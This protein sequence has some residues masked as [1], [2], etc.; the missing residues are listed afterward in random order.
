MSGRRQ[1]SPVGTR[2]LAETLSRTVEPRRNLHGS[3]H[4]VVGTD[5]EQGHLALKAAR[6]F[7][8]SKAES[9]S[10]TNRFDPSDRMRHLSTIEVTGGGSSSAT[11]QA[12]LP[13][14][15]NFCSSASGGNSSIN[16]TENSKLKNVNHVLSSP[17]K[18]GRWHHSSYGTRLASRSPSPAGKATAAAAAPSSTTTA[19]RGSILKTSSSLAAS[20][21]SKRAINGQQM[22]SSSASA[23]VPKINCENQENDLNAS[24]CEDSTSGKVLSSE[25]FLHSSSKE[26]QQQQQQPRRTI[27][28]SIRPN[29]EVKFDIPLERKRSAGHSD[30][31]DDDEADDDVDLLRPA[32]SGVVGFDDHSNGC[33]GSSRRSL[34]SP[35]FLSRHPRE[36]DA[37]ANHHYDPSNPMARLPK[38]EPYS[39]QIHQFPAGRSGPLHQYHVNREMDVSGRHHSSTSLGDNHHQYQGRLLSSS[40]TSSIQRQPPYLPSS[41]AASMNLTKESKGIPGSLGEG[42]PAPPG[43]IFHETPARK[44]LMA[45]TG[46]RHLPSDVAGGHSGSSLGGQLGDLR[47]LHGSAAVAGSSSA[48]ASSSRHLQEPYHHNN[49]ASTSSHMSEQ[50]LT[51][52]AAFKP[53]IRSNSTSSKSNSNIE[54]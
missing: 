11:G 19:T 12:L 52:V 18:S 49:Q 14:R 46:L 26:R 35:G 45:S 28:S 13:T 41:V 53:A 16:N 25:A 1:P 32:L 21:A 30:D 5:P 39:H 34:S 47:P 38:K 23:M 33:R 2:N 37:V 27:L 22:P 7:E 44:E 9:W 29:S 3:S 43:Q 15:M 51:N 17:E 4:L 10:R 31:D 36:V 20:S 40:S 24:F 42:G 6:E 54:G 48:S 50:L 8:E